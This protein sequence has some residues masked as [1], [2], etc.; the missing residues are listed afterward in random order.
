MSQMKRL[1]RKNKVKKITLT[2][3]Y[4]I[5]AKTILLSVGLANA[6]SLSWKNVDGDWATGTNWNTN[7]KPTA[8]DEVNINR[9]GK[10]ATISGGDET[11]HSF[12]MTSGNLILDGGNLETTGKAFWFGN[13]DGQVSTVTV[14]NGSILKHTGTDEFYVGYH[15]NGEGILNIESTGTVETVRFSVGPADDGKGTANVSGTLNSNRVTIGAAGVG[16]LNITGGTVNTTGTGTGT[17]VIIGSYTTGDG[18]VNVTNNGSW[19]VTG[20]MVVGSAGKGQLIIDDGAVSS[21]AQITVGNS[22][23]GNGTI[24]VNNNGILASDTAQ[25][26]NAQGSVGTVNIDGGSWTIQNYIRVG[27]DGE[28]TLTIDNGGTLTSKTIIVGNGTT[29][30]GALNLN[31]GTIEA[32]RILQGS[33]AGSFT[34]DGG[35]IKATA[36]SNSTIE[37]FNEVTI[38][39]NG[40]T[41]DSNGFSV[42]SKSAFAGNGELI[43]NGAGTLTLAAASNN[44]SGNTTV[45][46]GVLNLTVANAIAN[47]ATVHFKN[48]S[49][50]T[51][52]ADQQFKDLQMDVGT[53]GINMNGYNLTLNKGELGSVISNANTVTKNTTDTLNLNIANVLAGATTVDL[54]A[55]NIESNYNQTVNNLISHAGTRFD[56]TNANTL[57]VNGLLTG[58]GTL[59]GGQVVL[60]NNAI[61]ATGHNTIGTLNIDGDLVFQAGSRYQ[62]E[63]HPTNTAHSDFIQV[64]GTADLTGGTVHHIGLNGNYLPIGEWKILEAD[65]G[66]NGT[67]FAG[68]D[69]T[70][71]F[72]DAQLIYGS[73][74][75][76]SEWVKL[77]LTRN[78]VALTDYAYTPNQR[79]TASG[80][81][82]LKGTNN[83][84]YNK[85]LGLSTQTNIADVYDQLS[86]EIHASLHGVLLDYD[87]SFSRAMLQRLTQKSYREGYPLWI[88]V[89]GY[90]SNANRGEDYNTARTKMNTT[91]FTIGG[92]TMLNDW[93]VGSALRYGNSDLNVNKR[94]SSADIDSYSLGVY[95]ARSFGQWQLN[96]GGSYSWHEVDTKRRII[97]PSL[98]QTLKSDY[99]VQSLQLFSELGYRISLTDKTAIEPYVGI[100]WNQSRSSGFHERGLDAALKARKVTNENITSTVG[101]RFQLQVAGKAS[102]ELDLNWQH[103][104]GDNTPDTR[105]SFYVSER[106]TINGAPMSRNALGVRAGAILNVAPK[107]NLRVGYDGLYGAATESH[108]GYLTLEYTF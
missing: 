1:P 48:S 36:S 106:F 105:L 28:G 19:N 93:V 8:V 67:Q 74:G 9:P 86:G 12:R 66:L 100:A 13:A 76:L 51:A 22:D 90:N 89:D 5:F 35:T 14:K 58:T 15:N 7:S 60:G 45:N 34:I 42:T 39:T 70:Y 18:L 78:D 107:T 53:L 59:A 77:Q 20:G 30:N 81:N 33:G 96:L 3:Q 16:I 101:S 98:A 104:Y 83:T 94:H 25:I 95:G 46:E 85:V 69:Q 73:D 21:S 32:S 97:E 2:V 64:T 91:G 37:G 43:K 72:L 84:I 99:S 31:N 23:G 29:G 41:I 82:S 68:L 24:V 102:L 63:T 55:G 54:T 57:T 17:V 62:V 10:T 61:V 4:I 52:Y 75:G 27:N 49:R 87:R 11:I 92:E 47:S 38:G 108:G 50:L 79:A 88:T 26:G 65:S 71:L 103:L 44:F 80:I 56:V 6:A 40:A